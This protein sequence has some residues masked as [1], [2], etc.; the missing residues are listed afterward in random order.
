MPNWC[1]NHATLKHNDPAM[2]KRAMDAFLR[3]KLLSE[4][5]PVPEPL[6]NTVAGHVSEGYDREL[7]EFQQKLNVKHFGYANWYDFAIAEWGTKWDIGGDNGSAHL[8]NEN[9]LRLDFSSAWTPPTAFYDKLQGMGFEVEA[10]YCEPGAG[11]AGRH[12]AD[13]DDC[14]DIESELMPK[15]IREAFS[16]ELEGEEE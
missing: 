16:L 2:I 1:E 15:E 12:D 3:A 11:F 6:T 14:Y 9:T 8:E 7:H 10:L 13:G 5:V 4:F